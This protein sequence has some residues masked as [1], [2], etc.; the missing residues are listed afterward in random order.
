[1]LESLHALS[2]WV[3]SWAYTPYG[4]MALAMLAFAESSFFP[5]PPDVL[6]IALC[7]INPKGSL[8][9][10]AICSI[11]SVLGGGFGYG[12]GRYGGRPLL[13]RMFS[14]AKTQLVESYYQR[15]DVWAVGIAAF[16]PIPYKVFT[17]AAGVFLLDL[18][19]FMLASFIGRSGR[20]FMVAMLFFF[21]GKPIAAFI[22]SYLNI[23]SVLFVIALVGGF[24]LIH[25]WSRRKMNKSAVPAVIEGTEQKAIEDA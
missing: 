21:F 9:Y 6:L 20:F 7:L 22:R 3:I 8:I 5:I 1:M 12:L 2:N 16:T 17:I 19:R 25:Y 10:A 14:E 24:A 23:L 11:A 13:R 4:G 15:Y 18:K